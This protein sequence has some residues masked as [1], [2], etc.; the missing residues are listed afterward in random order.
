MKTLIL[1]G[2][3]LTLL[4]PLPVSAYDS[5]RAANNLAH[6]L[7]NCGAYFFLMAEMPGLK[8]DTKKALTERGAIAMETS[9][10]LTSQKV[11]WARF[12]LALEEMRRDMESDWSN[13]S[14]V[15][16]KYGYQCKD[17]IED[18]TSR[19]KYWQEKKD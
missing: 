9:T 17:L 3:A 12:S 14:V 18:P 11:A 10:G 8:E 2:F 1:L 4:L 15:H 6:E 7:A 16:A 13:V 19:M 5:Q